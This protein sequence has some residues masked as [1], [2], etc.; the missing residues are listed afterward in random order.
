M[1]WQLDGNAAFIKFWNI[2]EVNLHKDN[3]PELTGCDPW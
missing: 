3:N 1:L 2:T